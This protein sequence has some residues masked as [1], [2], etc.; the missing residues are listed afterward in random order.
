MAR[1]LRI[2]INALYLIPGG[3]GGTEIYLR[4]LL[5]AMAPVDTKNQF[6]VFTNRETDPELVPLQPNFHHVPQNVRASVRPARL[7][8]EQLALPGK[9]HGLGL[10]VL[11][12]PG[13][14][15]PLFGSCPNVTVFHDLQHKRHP[16]YFRWFDLPFWRFFLYWSAR[17]STRLIA[18]S[19]STRLDLLRFYPVDDGKIRVV[20]HGVEEAFFDV[21]RAR[22]D[23]E[24][25]HYVLCVST[26]HPHKNLDRLVRAFRRFHERHPL[27]RLIIAGMHGFQTSQIERTIIECGMGAH[28]H[29][30]GWIPREELLDLYCKAWAFVYPSLFEGFGMPVLEALASGIPCAVSCIE[31]MKGIAGSAALQFDPLDE[32]QIAASLERIVTDG[33]LRA[34]LR[35]AGPLRAADFS[36][37][38]AAQQTLRVV[39]AAARKAASRAGEDQGA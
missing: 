16:E 22:T 26:L 28:V 15:A 31:P 17:R 24:L 5:R 8:W 18:V 20:P 37:R 27:F 34:Q 2:G 33:D 25:R 23:Q 6:F 11:F 7:S 1:P 38:T 13:F 36:W 39:E 9:A 4:S 12:N 14:T 3:V 30:T 29:I 32:E 21:G 19:E 10:D 35:A